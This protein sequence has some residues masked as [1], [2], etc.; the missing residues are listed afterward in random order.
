M[1]LSMFSKVESITDLLVHM[2]T[3]TEEGRDTDFNLQTRTTA[4]LKF[5]P[6]T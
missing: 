1:H 3:H 4:S 5:F 2:Y 6:H